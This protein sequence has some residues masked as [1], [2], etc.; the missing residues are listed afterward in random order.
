MGALQN[1]RCFAQDFFSG[2]AGPAFKR[3]VHKHNARPLVLQWFSFC[4]EHDVIEVCHG[5]AQQFE[6]LF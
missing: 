1:A 4:N 3:I 6:L 2:V 5:G